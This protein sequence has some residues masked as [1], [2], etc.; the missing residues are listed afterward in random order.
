[1][2]LRIIILIV[3]IA[4]NLKV[5]A[6]NVNIS[7]KNLPIGVFDSGT[8]GL[9]VL[10]A[11]LQLDAYNNTTGLPGA[12]G[13]PDFSSEFFEYLADQANMPYGN[14]AAEKKTDLLKEHIFK[15]MQFLLQSNNVKQSTKMIVLACNTATAYALSDIKAKFKA[16][17]IQVPVI[18]V[19]DAGSKA[20]LAYQAK[21]GAGTI[22]VFATAGTVAS[23][24][25]PRT[26]QAMAKENGLPVL[27]VVSQGGAGLAESIDRDWSYFV[28]TLKQARK[29]YKGPSLKN[30]LYGIDTT[31]LSAYKFDQSSNKLLCEYDD[32]GS[33]LDMQLNDPANYVRYH[34][35][36]LLEKMVKQDVKTPMNTLIL[37]C[38]HYPYMRDTIA[39]VLNELYDYKKDNKYRYR[40]YLAKHVELI[41]PSVETAKEAYLALREKQLTNTAAV[42]QNRFFITIPNNNLSEAKLQPDGWFTY[43]YK[44]GRNAGEKKDYVQYVPF[45]HKNI[46]DASYER[47][48]LVLPSAYAEI[49]KTLKQ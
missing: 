47:F 19:I 46:S 14:Y 31:L 48:K 3:L 23:E 30:T 37:G 16:E 27:S 15:N 5:K 45:D 32:K 29:E 25:Y 26:L 40:N 2:K 18:G 34:L 6:Q 1:M 9:T 12:D 28:D 8:G 35:V 42:Q 11:M 44:Y 20:A 17:N 39:K 13:K 41:D 33:C 38:T 10:E 43:G 21:A 22:G 49:S 24:G 4:F 7:N 36:S